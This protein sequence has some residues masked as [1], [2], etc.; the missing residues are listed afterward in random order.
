MGADLATQGQEHCAGVPTEGW[1]DGMQTCVVAYLVQTRTTLYY[2]II[3]H[4]HVKECYLWLALTLKT[5]LYICCIL[6]IY[7]R[8]YIGVCKCMDCVLQ[9][10]M[11]ITYSI[12]SVMYLVMVVL[13]NMC[14]VVLCIM[15]VT[16]N[17]IVLSDSAVL[18]QVLA[19]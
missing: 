4:H 9:I 15:S 11:Y 1:E 17:F 16:Y 13:H 7:I 18:L 14:R 2:I 10:R 6:Q 5:V 12:Y 3:Y 19:R 8:M